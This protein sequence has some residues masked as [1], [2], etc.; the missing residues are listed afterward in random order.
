QYFDGKE[1]LLDALVEKLARDVGQ[2]L[3]RLPIPDNA[4][5][6]ERV[7]L[8][9]RFGFSVMH[10]ENGLY[11][12]LMRNWHRLPAD[13]VVDVLQQY[14]YDSAQLY[15]LKHYREYPVRELQAR[16]FIVINSTAFTLVRFF[17]QDNPLLG[18]E[19]IQA[20]LIEM[21]TGFMI[22]SDQT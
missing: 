19:A 17:S 9:I 20:G 4:T 5:L 8:A 14:F 1:A 15:F 7:S 6:H 11:L 13:R 12:E 18:E 21:I 22:G 2:A 16:V 10:S 3:V